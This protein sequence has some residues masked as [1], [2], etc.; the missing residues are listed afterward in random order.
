MGNYFFTDPDGDV[1]KVEYSFGYFLDAEGNL[2]INLHH[3]SLPYEPGV[4]E[5]MVLDAQKAWGDGIVKIAAAHTNGGDFEQEAKDHITDL[6]GYDH[7]PVNFKPT[8][9]AAMQ[10]RPTFEGALSYFVATNNVAPEDTGFAIKGWTKVVFENE[11]IITK[12]STAV[13]MGNYF[14]TKPDGS[15]AKVE[16]SFG[17]FLDEEGSLRINLHHSSLPYAPGVTE[18]MVLD[19]QKAW[20]DGIV[21][22]AAAHTNGLN[23]TQAA[24]DHINTLYG[25][26]QG[27]VLFKPTLAAEMQ[28]RPTFAGALSYF[29]ANN[30]VAPEDTGFAIKGWTKVEFENG[31]IITEGKTAV[32]MGNYF[33]TKPDDS[34]TKVESSF[35]YFLDEE[36]QLRINLHHSSLPYSP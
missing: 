7:G 6:Y 15:V 8:L 23:Y 31:V 18:A 29:V 1:A 16:Y 28:F 26:A 5:E 11:E 34:V 17:Y 24:V 3:S 20:G 10:F 13:A 35:G 30:N 32:A 14:F 12:G 22:I 25:Y 4:T 27:P 2:R 9:A 21:T 33:F 36:G 19:A